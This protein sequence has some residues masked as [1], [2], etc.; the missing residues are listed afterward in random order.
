MGRAPIFLPFFMSSIFIFLN[1]FF[2][3]LLRLKLNSSH[4][5]IFN[6]DLFDNSS[7][8]KKINGENFHLEV[9]KEKVL[10]QT[11]SQENH[12]EIFPFTVKREKAKSQK[13][14]HICSTVNDF[15]MEF[16]TTI[17]N[18]LAFHYKKVAVP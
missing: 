5:V 13:G 17:K 3:L 6:F 15:Q 9:S 1:I 16:L 7:T 2:L 10:Q 11:C 4:D 12:T 8:Q 14:K 18:C